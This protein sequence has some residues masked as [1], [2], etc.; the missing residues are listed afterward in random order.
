[1]K[2]YENNNF[3]INNKHKEV[4]LKAKEKSDWRNF[5]LR[6]SHTLLP[7]T[8]NLCKK[9]RKNKKKIVACS[10]GKTKN[11]KAETT[12]KK[13]CKR[14]PEKKKIVKETSKWQQQKSDCKEIV[15]LWK[16]IKNTEVL[17]VAW[18]SVE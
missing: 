14:K 8:D 12:W 9:E 17:C 6:F 4:K 7:T 5:S 18:F 15:F 3:L 16:T 11:K 2:I 10:V 1:M 13:S